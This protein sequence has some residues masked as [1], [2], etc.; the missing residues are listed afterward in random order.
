MP[1]TAV[2]FAGLAMAQ[3]SALEGLVKGAD[4]APLI[5]AVIR[6]D[7][8]DISGRYQAKTSKN[9]HYFYNGL[10][11]GTY[12]VTCNVDGKDVD[13]V[14]VRTQLGDPISVNFDLRATARKQE[15]PQRPP[16]RSSGLGSVYVNAENAADR[17]QLNTDGSFS[18]QEGG[19][20]FTGS[21]SVAGATLKLR[22]AQLQK[23][24]DILVQGN[25][26]VVNGQEIWTQPNAVG[27]GIAK[28][29][30][31][32]SKAIE[33]NPSEAA[34]HNN[35]A[36]ALGKAMKIPEMEAELKKAAE[37]DP[38]K[39]GQYYYNMGA[40]LLN[41]GQSERACATFKKAS[42]IDPKHADSYYQWGVCL[43]GKASFAADGK[44]IP[45]EGTAEAFQKYL[46]LAP[47]GQFADSA[48]SMLKVMGA[49]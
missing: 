34:R 33:V 11:L 38:P 35:L 15:Q 28:G 30:E 8:M 45:V 22:I 13:T 36:L 26:L 2:L 21:Y 49:K 20:S 6:I 42:E 40:M 41:A 3:I 16:D 1:I 48:K 18:L 19:Q 23:D 39:A 32:D 29:S 14:E 12:R 37:L 9:G 7:R 47:M 27:V 10:P 46:Q 24:V 5:G 25:E 31:S 4:G 17:L 44:V 43:I